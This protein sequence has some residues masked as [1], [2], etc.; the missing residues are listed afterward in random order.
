MS[1]SPRVPALPLRTLAL[2]ATCLVAAVAGA[3][4][5]ASLKHGPAPPPVG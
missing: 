3:L 5:A 4:M 2:L 1:E